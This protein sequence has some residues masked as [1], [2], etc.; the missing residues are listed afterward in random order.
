[1]MKRNVAMKRMV[2]SKL[3]KRRYYQMVLF[4]YIRFIQYVRRSSGGKTWGI[5]RNKIGH[6]T[7]AEIENYLQRQNNN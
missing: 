6:S 1:M 2:N 4:L 3:K 7:G 5:K